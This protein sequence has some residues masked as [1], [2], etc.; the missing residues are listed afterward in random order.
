[1]DEL[2]IRAKDIK[3]LLSKLDVSKSMGPDKIHP[4]ISNNLSSNSS[5]INAI[6]KLFWKC[7]KYEMIWETNAILLHKKSSIHLKSNYRPVSLISINFIGDDINCNQHCFVNGKSTLSNILDII[8]EYLSKG[9]LRISCIW[10]L[11]RNSIRYLIII[12]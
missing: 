9:V 2:I 3:L 4:K 11:V 1:M 8:D 7:V 5:F 10:I 6:C 12:Y